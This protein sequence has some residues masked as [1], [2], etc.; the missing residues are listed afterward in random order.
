MTS[1]CYKNLDNID[2]AKIFINKAYKLSQDIGAKPEIRNSAYEL[3][4]ILAAQ[5]K[6]DSAF[7]VQNHYIEINDQINNEKASKKIAELEAAIEAKKQEQKIALLEK[8]KEFQEKTKLYYLY[9]GVVLI[10]LFV[11]MV[12]FIYN[13]YKMKKKSAEALEVKNRIIEEKNKDIMDSIR[14]AKKIQEAILPPISYIRQYFPDSFVFYLPKD[15]VAGDFYW[16]N[17][18]NNKYMIA[19]CDCTGH[20]V[21]GAMVSVMCCNFLNRVVKELNI[22]DPGEILNKVRELVVENF[23]KSESQMKDGMDISLCVFEKGNNSL[24]WAGANNSLWIVRNNSDK[25][26]E[27]KADKQPVGNHFEMKPFTTHKINFSKGDL[28]Y[29]Y[30]DGYADQFGGEKGKKFKSSN[31]KKLMIQVSTVDLDSQ[32]NTLVDTFNNWK[33]NNEQVDDVTVVGIRV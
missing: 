7:I 23:K 5:G 1:I 28:F 31:F 29:L 32:K 3:S 8:D 16:M 24:L 9:I 25:V 26:E 33:G 13:R 15:V 14:Y 11:A 12:L 18:H 6:F 19:A 10:L 22:T 2:S 21:P 4:R 30:S 17:E 27:I 20:G